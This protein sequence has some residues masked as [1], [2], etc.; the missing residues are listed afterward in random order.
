MLQWPGLCGDWPAGVLR[1]PVAQLGGRPPAPASKKQEIR[2]E[3]E[4]MPIDACATGL[5][6]PASEAEDGREH[7]AGVAIVCSVSAADS[8]PGPH[9]RITWCR[10]GS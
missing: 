1:T 6:T 7:F 10:T 9:G 2:E 5:R 8:Q 3:S 4:A